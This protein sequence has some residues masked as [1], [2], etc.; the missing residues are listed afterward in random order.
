VAKA[1]TAGALETR[2]LA[3][4][5]LTQFAEQ[6]SHGI[7]GCTG[8]RIP[9]P[10]GQGCRLSG[11]AS[12]SRGAGDPFRSSW[13]RRRRASGEPPAAAAYLTAS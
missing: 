10:G 8:R 11:G 13:A 1:M 6:A 4:D 5:H 9:A 3:Q 7:P 2:E 12:E